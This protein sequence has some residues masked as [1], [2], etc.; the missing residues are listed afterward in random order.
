MFVA[1]D[2]NH[3]TVVGNEFAYDVS[4]D[5]EVFG[6]FYQML[7]NTTTESKLFDLKTK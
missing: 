5:Y 2:F 4:E 7:H 6:Y 1:E 3:N